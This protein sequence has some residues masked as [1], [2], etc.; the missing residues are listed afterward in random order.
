[1]TERQLTLESEIRQVLAKGQA[2]CLFQDEKEGMWFGSVYKN[3]QGKLLSRPPTKEGIQYA[4]Q[5]NRLLSSPPKKI[6][7]P[8]QP[9]PSLL[10]LPRCLSYTES[11]PSNLPPKHCT[12]VNHKAL[13]PPQVH[14]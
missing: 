7:P 9:F 14:P 1:M 12:M 10:L 6:S 13:P 5:F 3:K 11:R 2:S 4:Q 8:L